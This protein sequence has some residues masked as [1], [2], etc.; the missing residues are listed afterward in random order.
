LRIFLTTGF[1]FRYTALRL[2]SGGLKEL[3]NYDD[4]DDDDQD[5]D[6]PLR[7]TSPPP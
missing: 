3:Q 7:H 1:S 2:A 6:D 5:S 4:Q